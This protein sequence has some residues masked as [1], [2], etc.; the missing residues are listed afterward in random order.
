MTILDKIVAAKRKELTLKKLVVPTSQ[1]EN[2]ALFER[3]T[4][5]LHDALVQS[6]TGIIA[7]FKR[8]SP[9]KGT[10]NSEI[11]VQDVVEGYKN[12]GATG[13]SV[14]TDMNFF[15]GSIED[16][17]LAR[18][19]VN[20]PI[21]RKEFIVDEYQ[22]LEAKAAGADVILLIASVLSKDE[23][24][25]LSGFAQTLKLEVLVEIHNLGELDRS[26]H[27]SVDI[28]GINNRNLKTFEVDIQISATLANH[29]PSE[30]LKISESGID[31]FKTVAA[32][33]QLGYKGFLIGE[34]Y[35]KTQNPGQALATFTNQLSA[36]L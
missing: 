11:A 29:I 9:S 30:F 26:L 21:L 3:A 20:I 6:P 27:Q 31:N 32:L 36:G 19:T 13:I 15:G 10:I 28:I 34:T 24:A 1:L 7:E 8:R 25:Q 12:A 4:L 17:L 33:R 35:M 18:A 14:L 5:S 2:S 16:L 23:I 22:I